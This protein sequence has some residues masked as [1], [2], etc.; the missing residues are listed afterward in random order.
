MSDAARA[1]VST[2]AQTRTAARALA[3]EA[4]RLERLTAL[5]GLQGGLG[6]KPDEEDTDMSA[7]AGEKTS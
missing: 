7:D 3:N 2:S 5:F 4:A 1:T 6:P